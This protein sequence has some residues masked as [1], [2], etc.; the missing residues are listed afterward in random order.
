MSP[1]F[2]GWGC[3]ERGPGAPFLTDASPREEPHRISCKAAIGQEPVSARYLALVCP[4]SRKEP[5]SLASQ[6]C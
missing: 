4:R 2:K 6:L 5:F 3:A 1:A